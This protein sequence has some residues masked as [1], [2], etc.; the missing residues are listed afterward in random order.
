MLQRIKQGGI[1]YDIGANYGMHALLMAK[2][3]GASG[4]VY[5]FEPDPAIFQGLIEHMEL[6]RFHHVKCVQAGVWDHSGRAQ[7]FSGHHLGAGHC[8]DVDGT[9]GCCTEIE[10]FSLDD[11]VFDRN[12]RPPDF[13]KVDVEGA[14]SKVL[15]GAR[16]LLETHRPVLLID[17]HNPEQDVVVGSTLAQLG[18]EARRTTDE[19]IIANMFAGW[20]QADGV[21][22]QI[23][24]M[25]HSAP[26]GVLAMNTRHS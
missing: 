14:E 15:F 2:L 22:G 20:P 9:S 18:Y 3:V 24:A 17:L 13:I 21:W 11:F 25:H 26:N 8:A 5:A 16:R 7:F 19:K 6:N 10:V 4:H 1:V 23:V 12:H